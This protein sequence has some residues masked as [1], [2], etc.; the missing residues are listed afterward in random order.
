MSLRVKL[1]SEVLIIQH[2]YINF[3]CHYDKKINY[4]H[5][6]YYK[7]IVYCTTW[8]THSAHY[9]TKKTIQAIN[10]C[11]DVF[12]TLILE[13]SKSWWIFYDSLYILWET[14][15][16]IIADEARL[17]AQSPGGTLPDHGSSPTQSPGTT[18][19]PAIAWF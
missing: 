12:F 13:L 10:T 14:I 2:L 17:Q 19:L 16:H 18:C 11:Q 9:Y 8:S 1:T 15:L 7:H 3:T 6:Y 4:L 5:T